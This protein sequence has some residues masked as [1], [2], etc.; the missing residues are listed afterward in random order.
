MVQ[1]FNDILNSMWPCPLSETLGCVFCPVTFGL[2]YCLPNMC[3]K[4][5]EKSVR[6]KIKY[7]NKYRLREKGLKVELV[8]KCSTSWLE[9]T[10]LS[11]QEL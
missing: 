5:A 6:W 8:K 2:S 10:Y 9:L 3:I 4:D 1:T 11:N 7:Y